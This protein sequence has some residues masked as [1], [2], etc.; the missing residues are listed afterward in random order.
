MLGGVFAAGTSSYE[1][2]SGLEQ[3]YSRLETAIANDEGEYALKIPALPA[4]IR[5]LSNPA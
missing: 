5:V 4:T 3:V 2:N 1:M